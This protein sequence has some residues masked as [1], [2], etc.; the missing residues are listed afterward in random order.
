MDEQRTLVLSAKRQLLN[1]KTCAAAA[2]RYAADDTTMEREVGYKL[3][4]TEGKAHLSSIK[5]AK[6][7][8]NK[9][10]I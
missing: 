10:E 8:N 6:R 4:S 2:F 5:G 7:R 9:K 3:I 1:L